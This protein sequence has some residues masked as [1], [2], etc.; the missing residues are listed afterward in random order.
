MGGNCFVVVQSL[1]QVRLFAAP[2]TA[3]HQVSLSFLISQSL[4]RLM[5]IELMMPSN[6]L[7]AYW[8]Y[9]DLLKTTTK[10]LAN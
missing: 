10:S 8:K 9:I 1:S 6:H 5:S 4:L 3:A 2:W 7:V